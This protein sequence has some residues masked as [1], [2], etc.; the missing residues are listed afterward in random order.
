VA[1]A[2]FR[3]RRGDSHEVFDREGIHGEGMW[4]RGRVLGG[5]DYERIDTLR[6]CTSYYDAR[7][8]RGQEGL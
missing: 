5:T 7:S 6:N 2:T 3:V 4:T 1:R 8:F